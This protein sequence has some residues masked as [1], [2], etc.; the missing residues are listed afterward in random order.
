MRPSRVVRL[1]ERRGPTLPGCSALFSRDYG[2]HSLAE[3]GPVRLSWREST[4]CETT[5]DKAREDWGGAGGDVCFV[6]SSWCF[7]W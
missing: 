2:T 5:G 7:D 4:V 6:S 3:F 1:V